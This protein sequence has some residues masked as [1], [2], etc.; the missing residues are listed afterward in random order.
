MWFTHFIMEL[1]PKDSYCM[2]EVRIQLDNGSH[3]YI[4]LKLSNRNVKLLLLWRNPI[5]RGNFLILN[6]IGLGRQRK[7][8]VTGFLKIFLMYSQLR[9]VA[10]IIRLTSVFLNNWIQ[11]LV[12]HYTGV[13]FIGYFVL[14][15]KCLSRSFQVYA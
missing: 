1:F 13:V 9:L 12:W 2:P 8:Y 5:C 7:K 3:Q 10:R 14:A 4:L 11:W 6:I 15:D